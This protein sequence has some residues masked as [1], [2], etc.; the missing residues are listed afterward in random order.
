M[1][2]AVQTSISKV[3]AKK[4]F[5]KH[6]KSFKLILIFLHCFRFFDDS[7]LVELRI[8]ILKDYVDYFVICEAKQNHRGS[9]KKLNFPFEKFNHLREK[10]IYISFDNFPELN[11]TW[12]R[13]DYQRNY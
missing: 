6:S 10:I 5:L 13:Q 3:Q 2:N 7:D 12:E 8:N 9:T 4:Y 11:S 1:S